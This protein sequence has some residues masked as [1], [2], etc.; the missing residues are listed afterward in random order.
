MALQIFG[1]HTHP[2]SF[3]VTKADVALEECVFLLDFSRPLKRLRWLGVYNEW[4]GISVGLFVPVVHKG[5]S[6]GGY[7][8]SVRRAEPYF[9]DIEKLWRKHRG[10]KRTM[11]APSVEPA[12]IV[13]DFA[14]HFPEDCQ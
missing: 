14:H 4:V 5:E 6:S 8:F 13:A 9:V 2:G 12:Q 7:V 11:V 3:P 1:F 10:S